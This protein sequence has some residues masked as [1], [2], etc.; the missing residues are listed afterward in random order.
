MQSLKSQYADG[1]RIRCEERGR[2]FRR[3]K[4]LSNS[5]PQAISALGMNC[6]FPPICSTYRRFCSDKRLVNCTADVRSKAACY[7]SYQLLTVGVLLNI[8]VSSL[9]NSYRRSLKSQSA[10]QNAKFSDSLTVNMKLECETSFKRLKMLDKKTD[11]D[12][13]NNNAYFFN[14]SHSVVLQRCSSLVA[15]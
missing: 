8:K 11:S 14:M 4:P 13:K 2:C 12:G 10:A 5:R 1:V 6:V 7:V 3:L 15:V 9:V